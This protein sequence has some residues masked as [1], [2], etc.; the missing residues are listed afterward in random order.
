MEAGFF[1]GK[2]WVDPEKKN[3]THCFMA[4]WGLAITT[5]GNQDAAIVRTYNTRKGV[6]IKTELVLAMYAKN[7]E[8]L[9]VWG[10]GEVAQT[11]A[12]IEKGD[13]VF[14]VGKERRYTYVNKDGEQKESRELTPYIVFAQGHITGI[15]EILADPGIQKVMADAAE[16]AAAADMAL[17]EDQFESAYDA[18]GYEGESDFDF[19]QDPIEANPDLD[20]ETYVNPDLPP[21]PFA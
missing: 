1:R 18:E 14:A 11:L 10:D 6:R 4:V 13:R 19:E 5:S 20:A 12:K 7:F 17:P 8:R 3:E 15:E 9:V 16:A 21:P 2:P